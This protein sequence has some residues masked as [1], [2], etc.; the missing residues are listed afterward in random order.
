MIVMQVIHRQ[1]DEIVQEVRKNPNGKVL[2]MIEEDQR[3]EDM[4]GGMIYKKNLFSEK[5]LY[6]FL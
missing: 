3:I 1:E 5:N 2:K 6:S 4:I